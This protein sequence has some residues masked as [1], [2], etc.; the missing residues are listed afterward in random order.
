MSTLPDGPDEFDIWP[1][2]LESLNLFLSCQTQWNRGGF[3]GK[4]LGLKYTEVEAV[5]RMQGLTD[6]A[7]LFNDIRDM[8]YAALSEF[9]KGA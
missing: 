9:N 1:E 8:E 6:Q 7:K 3:N 4:A 2:N 5:M